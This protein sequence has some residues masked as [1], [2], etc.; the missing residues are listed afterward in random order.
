MDERMQFLA[1]RLAGESMAELCGEFGIARK[2]GRKTFDRYQDC[3][4]DKE[5]AS[6]CCS[7]LREKPSVV[8][9]ASPWRCLARARPC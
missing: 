8:W 3:G 9:R 4:I 1:R 5:R 6:C 2:T 7:C